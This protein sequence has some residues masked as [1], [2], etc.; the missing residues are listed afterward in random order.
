MKQILNKNYINN[1]YLKICKINLYN[2]YCNNITNKLNYNIINNI[3]SNKKNHIVS[4]FKDYLLYDDIS[5]FFKRFYNSSESNARIKKLS[6]FYKDTSFLFPNYSSLAESKY[7]YSNIIKKQMVINKQE[8]YKK[9]VKNNKIKRQYQEKIDRENKN[10]NI[11]FN[12]IV[13]NDILNESKSFMSLLFG[14]EKKSNICKNNNIEKIKI[15][16]EKEIEELLNIIDIIETNEAVDNKVEVI[17]S[18]SMNINKNKFF[19]NKDNILIVKNLK[20]TKNKLFSKNNN[21]FNVLNSKSP[22]SNKHKKNYKHI[23]IEK[24]SNNIIENNKN[25]DIS[26]E[27]NNY[28]NSQ[29]E[30]QDLQKNKKATF[31]RKVNST[32]IG[33]YLNKLELLPSNSNVINMLKN[34]NETYAD[35]MNKNS[36]R[37]ILY[38]TVKNNIGFEMKN[39]VKK[40]I[41]PKAKQNDK[42]K[43]KKLENLNSGIIMEDENQIEQIQKIPNSRNSKIE[44]F[45]KKIEISKL[46]HKNYLNKKGNINLP[47]STRNKNETISPYNYNKKSSEVN[48]TISNENIFNNTNIIIKNNMIKYEASNSAFNTNIKPEGGF[49]SIFVNPNLT[50]PYSKPKCLH[51]EKKYNR[52]SARKLFSNN[53]NDISNNMKE[54]KN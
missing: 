30:K 8:N 52:I 53:S 11:F 32:L 31:H 4:L 44:R 54:K 13:Y 7:L 39:Q 16:S 15:D 38:Q 46:Y 47:L 26:K 21:I 14:V 29:E 37:S 20:N 6:K 10:E 18:N 40:V 49:K 28:I 34:A 1:D 33:D 24:I 22:L 12:S 17:N 35:N 3:L 50:G 36:L 51:I 25:N 48:N 27:N 45:I 42:S 5:E 43:D 19:K 2:N 23:K 41:L 9:K